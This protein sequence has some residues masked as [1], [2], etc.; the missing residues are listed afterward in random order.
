MDL[1]LYN[2][3][4][5]ITKGI[6]NCMNEYIIK[7]INNPSLV[8]SKLLLINNYIIDLLYTS[9]EL[10]INSINNNNTINPENYMANSLKTSREFEEKSK[11]LKKMEIKNINKKEDK[12]ENIIY[13]YI[14]N[15]NFNKKSEMSPK[16]IQI[17]KLKR[18]LK[19]EQTKNTIKE[20]SYLQRLNDIQKELFLY[21]LKNNKEKGKDNNN[22]KRNFI[23][24]NNSFKKRNISKPNIQFNST[25]TKIMKHSIS[26]Y[27][28]KDS[29][30]NYDKYNYDDMK[31][32]FDL[33]RKRKILK[34]N[35][36]MKYDFK[37]IKKSIEKKIDSIK[38]INLYLPFSFKKIK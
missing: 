1:E 16:Q 33:F 26:Q 10:Q 37:E 21:E 13:S 17:I 15:N 7:N 35:N 11:I 36:E 2:R 22:N 8:E 29:T 32:K 19:D 23:T 20:L 9:E 28:I 25:K 34:R 31:L 18:K 38:G 30:I 6:F 14:D 12:N 5:V 27:E 24:T 4:R 3:F